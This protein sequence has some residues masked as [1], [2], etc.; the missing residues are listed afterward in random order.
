MSPGL[1]GNW[2]GTTTHASITAR[3]LIFDPLY[4]QNTRL[5]CAMVSYYPP[6]GI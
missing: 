3:K 2:A 1:A 6:N 4:L 5:S